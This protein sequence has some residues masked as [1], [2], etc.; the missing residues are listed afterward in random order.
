M[1]HSWGKAR[2]AMVCHLVE[3]ERRRGGEEE[4]RGGQGRAGEA[5]RHH[6]H[7]QASPGSCLEGARQQVAV[8]QALQRRVGLPVGR[9]VSSVSATTPH[10]P[11]RRLV[12][13][14]SRTR[15]EGPNQHQQQQQGLKQFAAVSA[16]VVAMH[17]T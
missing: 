5:P 10:T 4:R 3:E 1:G 8:H 13:L 11:A 12:H 16:V 17:C 14:G 7:S 6:H 9:D 15:R 2:A